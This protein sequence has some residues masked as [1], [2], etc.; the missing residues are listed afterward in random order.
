M[1]RTIKM[2]MA[3]LSAM[4]LALRLLLRGLLLRLGLRGLARL[5]LLLRLPRLVCG[6]RLA[7]GLLAL[8]L[9]LRRTSTII[10]ILTKLAIPQPAR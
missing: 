6:G 8:P 5:G 2:N 7:R 3:L 4:L 9:R 1:K 10:L